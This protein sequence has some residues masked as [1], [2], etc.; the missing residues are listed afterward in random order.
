MRFSKK[1]V[2]NCLHKTC[3]PAIL[4]IIDAFAASNFKNYFS[5][6]IYILIFGYNYIFS[7]KLPNF[8]RFKA[9]LTY[10]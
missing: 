10:L 1:I 3:I 4:Q 6:D 8:E 2:K 5:I 7:N 9:Y